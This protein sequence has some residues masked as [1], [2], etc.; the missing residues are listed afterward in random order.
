[1]RITAIAAVAKNRVIGSQGAIPWYIPQ[2]FAR[3]KRITMNG[4]L[5]MGR[6][7]FESIGK[8]LP[9]R[10]SIVISRKPLAESKPS[11]DMLAAEMPEGTSVHWAKNIDQALTLAEKLAQEQRV[12]VIGGAEIYRLA[13]DNITDLDLTL[14][15]Q[16]PEGD[17]IFPDFKDGW[18]ETQREDFAGYSFVQYSRKNAG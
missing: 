6:K 17:A 7:T 12:F 16:E 13:W 9:G 2:D 14:V 5:I 11:A 18:Q 8:P 15:A 1:M 10:K 4:V 3:F